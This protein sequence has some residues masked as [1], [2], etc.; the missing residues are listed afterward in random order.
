MSTSGIRSWYRPDTMFKFKSRNVL[1]NL[2]HPGCPCNCSFGPNHQQSTIHESILLYVQV[3][4]RRKRQPALCWTCIIWSNMA[5]ILVPI[6]RPKT[7]NAIS[8][9]CVQHSVIWRRQQIKWN[10]LR[11]RNSLDIRK[12]NWS[13]YIKY[14]S[15]TSPESMSNHR[16]NRAA[17][18]GKLKCKYLFRTSFH[19]T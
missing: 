7:M 5:P 17:A 16:I 13:S 6:C 3:S 14:S 18:A 9:N 1:S 11:A 10:A 2:N 8:I 15:P 12:R 4:W 19:A